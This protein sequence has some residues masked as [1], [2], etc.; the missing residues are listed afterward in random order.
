V[1]KNI[2]Q[3]VAIL[4][5]SVAALCAAT[6]ERWVHVRV[7]SAKGVSGNVSINVPI[8]MA[9]A[10]L[11]SIPAGDQHH[12]RFSLQAS[13]NGMDLRAMLDA[14]RNSPDN[15]FVTLERHDKEVSVAKSGRNLLI[16]I[17]DKPG[18]DNHLG[19]TIAI[20]VPV[21]VVRAM[22]ADNSDDLDVGAGIRALSREGDVDVTVN[23]EKET[24][25]VWTDTHTASD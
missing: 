17:V 7:E 22:L 10:V 23:S 18:A 4:F 2:F 9:S 3:A 8:E 25:R 15:V 20:K 1:T 14:V 19:K 13:V 5:L 16:K 24:V 6:A 12:G 11:P 21:A